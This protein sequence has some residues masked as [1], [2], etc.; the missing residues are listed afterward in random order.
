[1]LIRATVFKVRCPGPGINVVANEYGEPNCKL[2]KISRLTNNR[3][4][5]PLNP[6]SA[7]SALPGVASG[8]RDKGAILAEFVQ[9]KLAFAHRM[10]H[11]PGKT[12]RTRAARSGTGDRHRIQGRV[13]NRRGPRNSAI[14]SRF[15]TNDLGEVLDTS[16]SCPGVSRRTLFPPRR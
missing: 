15:E 3:S 7:G 4:I 8:H 1:M 2:A 11:E 14:R 12:Q 5:S 6:H 16:C 9:T 10:G 13:R